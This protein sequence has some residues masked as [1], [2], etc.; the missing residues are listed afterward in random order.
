[1]SALRKALTHFSIADK[2]DLIRDIS[3]HV[4]RAAAKKWQH[5]CRTMIASDSWKAASDKAALLI[6]AGIG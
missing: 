2:G 1:V 6:D 5:R 3:V 4:A